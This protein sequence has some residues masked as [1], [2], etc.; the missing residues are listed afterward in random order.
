MKN[1]NTKHEFAYY[2]RTL[3]EPFD[4]VEE[5]LE[6]EEA[7]YAKLKAKEDKA[8]AKKADASKV[9]TAFKELNQARKEYKETMAKIAETYRKN[10][11]ELKAAFEEEQAAAVAS[12]VGGIANVP[13]FLGAL[14]VSV[15]IYFIPPKFTMLGLGIY[16]PFYLSF[17]ACL[18]GLLALVLKK[19]APNFEKSGDANIVASGLLAGEGFVGVVIAL[20]QAIMILTA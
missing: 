18:G 15:I 16:L 1:K 14:A 13:A 20:I 4:T 17:S 19:V 2:S 12:V 8:A 3:Q 6:A 11:T 10:L 5:L 9:E 7:Y